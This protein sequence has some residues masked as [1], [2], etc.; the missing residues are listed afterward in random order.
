MID[1]DL[2]VRFVSILT[3]NTYALVLAG[4]RGSRLKNLTDWRAKQQHQRDAA[5]QQQIAELLNPSA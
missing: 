1:T 2:N 3:K 5:L 4:G